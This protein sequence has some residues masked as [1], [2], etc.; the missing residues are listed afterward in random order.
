MVVNEEFWKSDQRHITVDYEYMD[1]EKLRNHGG[2][3][4]FEAKWL[5]EDS[6]DDIV[7]AAWERAQGGGPGNLALRGPCGP[8][9][10]G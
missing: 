8:A 5:M 2:K 4:M 3:K 6:F 1:Q 9:C 10:M 7:R